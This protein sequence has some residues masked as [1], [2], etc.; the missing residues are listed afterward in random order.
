MSRFFTNSHPDMM[1]PESTETMRLIASARPSALQSYARDQVFSEAF[2]H[3]P[4]LQ[5]EDCASRDGVEHA[6]T[7]EGFLRN[8]YPVLYPISPGVLKRAER[9]G[10]TV[11]C[12]NEDCAA[13]YLI[14]PTPP[15]YLWY[16]I[17]V[18]PNKT[19]LEEFPTYRILRAQIT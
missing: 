6:F 8:E 10:G 5:C 19:S 13:E 4:L 11:R 9:G 18:G 16:P 1:A 12:P 3:Y 2:W 15:R 14:R 7:I 17:P